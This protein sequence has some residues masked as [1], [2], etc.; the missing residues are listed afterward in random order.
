MRRLLSGLL[1]ALLWLSGTS[2][3]AHKLAPSLLEIRESPTAGDYEISWK[4]PRFSPTPVPIVPRLPASCR[5]IGEHNALYEGTGVRV[6][7]RMHCPE[8]LSGAMLR[9][10][11]L[12]ENQSAALVRIEWS[13]GGVSQGLL[14]GTEEGFRVP[15][16]A[17]SFGVFR[18]YLVLGFGHI[19]GGVDH[20]LFVLG[21]LLLAG[22]GKQLVVTVTAFTAGHSVTLALAALGFLRYPVD[23]VE[24]GIS[25][26]ILV[27]AMELGRGDLQGAHLLRRYPW[28][29]AVL[30]GLLHGMGFAG[31]LREAGLP[32]GE[33]PLALLSFNV[34]IEAGQLAFVA[35][36]MLLA[37]AF[38]RT[39]LVRHAWLGWV[40]VYLIGV[41]SAYWCI[42]RGLAAV[43]AL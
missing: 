9:V 10:D 4:T 28:G 41:L 17:G 8:P 24:F 31:A 15:E 29:A 32:E 21:L 36:A 37:A 2:A 12:S 39:P 16:P 19:L 18:D 38:R 23:L 40:P 13:S 14:N 43:A 11:G 22:S 6:R 7:W 34:G 1:C 33:I 20:L 3:H 5:D 42:E 27:V 35:M 26:S 30:F 25:L